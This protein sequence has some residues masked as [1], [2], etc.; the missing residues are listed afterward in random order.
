LTAAAAARAAPP[1]AAS[2]T[3]GGVRLHALDWGGEG[4]ALV[5][6]PGAGQSA[7]VFGGIAP[8]F[9]DRARVLGLTPRGHGPSDTPPGGYTVARFADDLAGFLDAAGVARAVVAA[10]SM[11]GAVATR[12]A[13]SHPDRV[14]GLVYL[15]GILD[16]AAWPRLQRIA[17]V[18]PPP[19]PPPAADGAAE[20]DWLRRYHYG[21]WT[22]AVEADWR[23][24][25]AAEVVRL[26]RALLAQYMDDVVRQV[27]P[28]AS[29]RA[30]ALAICAEETVATL[31]P[32]LEADDPRYARAAAHVAD[33]R[34]PWR[35]ASAERFLREAPRG[36]VVSFPA[37]H[38]FFLHARARV[39]EEMRRF[40]DGLPEG[41]R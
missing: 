23:A 25:P 18:R 29:V 27:P 9:A 37:H 30:P 36:R 19:V 10:H 1:R 28:Y 34:A 4:G 41:A 8:A 38:F 31:Y 11:G 5:W 17:P 33:E 26:R 39:V 24:R 21:G 3:V 14:A 2:A 20:K 13:A 15:D 16:Y 7:H 22:P 35:A 6:V 32:W 40:L 12:F